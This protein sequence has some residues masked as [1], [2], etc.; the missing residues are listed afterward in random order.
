VMIEG[1]ISYILQC[2]RRLERA[3]A[4]YM[5][6]R[7]EVQARFNAH[8]RRLLSATVWGSGCRAYFV[9]AAGRVVTQWPKPSRVYRWLT[10]RVKRS[11]YSFT[12]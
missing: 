7:A 11:D 5:D 3:R 9:N 8:I 1:Q 6:V 12:T 10:R 2:I 4:R